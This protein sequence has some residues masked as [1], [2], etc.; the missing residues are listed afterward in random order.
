M[1]KKFAGKGLQVISRSLDDP[2]D[3]AAVKEAHKLLESKKS[4]IINILLD[5]RCPAAA[6]RN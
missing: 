6:S 1:H 2:D 5:E 4:S 3:E